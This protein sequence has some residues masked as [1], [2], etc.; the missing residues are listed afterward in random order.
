M[1]RDARV[2][3]STL[4]SR[5]PHRMDVDG[6][7]VFWAEGTPQLGASLSFRVGTADEEFTH[8]GITHLVEHLA[9]YR[10]RAVGH[11]ALTQHAAQRLGL[12]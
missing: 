4:G 12:C 11:H 3:S 2:E 6:V 1:G 10:L 5:D 7:P 8:T 9:L